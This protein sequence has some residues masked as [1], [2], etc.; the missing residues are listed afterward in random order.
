MLKGS[1]NVLDYIEELLEQGY[2]EDQA[3]I[4]AEQM[5]DMLGGN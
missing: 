4:C 3:E 5:L 2:T 1:F